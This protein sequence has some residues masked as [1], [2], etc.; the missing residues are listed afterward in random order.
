MGYIYASDRDRKRRRLDG[1]STRD[2]RRSDRDRRLDCNVKTLYHQTNE[3]GA[4]AIRQGGF[5]R[6][7]SS[8]MAGSGIYFA[9]SAAE[10]K[11]KAHKHGVILTVRV[12]LG[13]VKRIHHHGDK[14]ITFSSLQSEGYDSVEIPRPGGTEYV[15]Y[16]RDQAQVID[17]QRV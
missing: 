5:R 17:S 11:K 8:C 4:G 3:A 16:N 15:V 1:T 12:R 10:T 14:S 9:E 7:E 13:R 6:G 2:S